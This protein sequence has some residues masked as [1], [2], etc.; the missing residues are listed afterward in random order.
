ML[1]RRLTISYTFIF[2]LLLSFLFL[3]HAETQVNWI[4]DFDQAKND[5]KKQSKHIFVDVFADWCTWCH[6][7]DKEVYTDSKFQEYMKSFMPVKINAE[8]NK[9]G[10]SFVTKYDVVTLPTLIVTDEKGALL[11][12]IEGFRNANDLISEIDVMENLRVR[13]SQDPADFSAIVEQADLH[14]HYRM[15][16]EAEEGLKKVLS[17]SA[18]EE[19]KE[20]ATFVLAQVYIRS[21][22]K[23]KAKKYLKEYLQKYPQGTYTGRAQEILESLN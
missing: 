1:Q 15:F 22:S 14:S 2:A 19:I 5:A 10:A 17:S 21:N 12:R 13:T 8:D 11:A 4:Q 7:L 6:V 9:Y 18:Q 23:G 16:E 3:P 20:Q